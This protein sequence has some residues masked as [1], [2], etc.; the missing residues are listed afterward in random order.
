MILS[1]EER[2]PHIIDKDLGTDSKYVDGHWNMEVNAD[3]LSV[4]TAVSSGQ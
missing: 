1:P 4:V 2:F 3:W